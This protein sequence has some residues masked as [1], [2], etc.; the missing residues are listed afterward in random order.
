MAQNLFLT[1]L[2]ILW[3]ALSANC[4]TCPPA[5]SPTMPKMSVAI[6]SINQKICLVTGASRGIGRGIALGLGEK[7]NPYLRVTLFHVVNQV[8]PAYFS[9]LCMLSILHRKMCA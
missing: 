3:G 6:T 7:V 8:F 5:L 4:Y 9:T 1:S 2:M